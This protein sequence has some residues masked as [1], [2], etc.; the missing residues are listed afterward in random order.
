MSAAEQNPNLEIPVE[1]EVRFA[2]VMYG[3]VSL[4]IYIN[5]VTQELVHMVRATARDPDTNKMLFGVDE[6][7]ETEKVYRKLAREID[8]SAGV[9][10]DDVTLT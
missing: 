7:S 9:T 1:R 6:L 2:V 5:G 8:N 10:S 4:A 3:G